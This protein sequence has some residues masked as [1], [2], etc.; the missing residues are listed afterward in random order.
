MYISLVP[1]LSLSSSI[2]HMR[3]NYT[4]IGKGEGEPGMESH[5][6]VAFWPWFGMNIIIHPHTPRNVLCKMIEEAL[7]YSH[8]TTA[9]KPQMGMIPY[10]AD[11]PSPSPICI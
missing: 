5:P 10:H 8:Q 4:L 9:G 6:S 1:R 11:S 2:L 7:A 3:A